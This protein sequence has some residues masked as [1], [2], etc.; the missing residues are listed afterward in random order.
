MGEG[1]FPV[2]PELFDAFE[3]VHG[4]R[5]AHAHVDAVQVGFLAAL[6]GHHVPDVAEVVLQTAG[7]ARDAGKAHGKTAEHQPFGYRAHAVGI[8]AGEAFGGGHD[9]FERPSHELGHVGAVVFARHQMADAP[10]AHGNIL[11]GHVAQPRPQHA[12]GGLGHDLGVQHDACGAAVVQGALHAVYH[13]GGGVGGEAVHAG[14]GAHHDLGQLH[15]KAEH[16]A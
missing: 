2:G 6:Q 5:G 7:G 8:A 15:V 16:L 10:L 1:L 9:L 11:G 13:H 12:H 3:D 14:G 4:Q